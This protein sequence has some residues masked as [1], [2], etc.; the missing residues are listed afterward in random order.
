MDALQLFLI[1]HARA[2]SDAVA[3]ASGPLWLQDALLVGLTD[4]QLRL[5]PSEGD[6]SLAWLLW[7]ITRIEDVAMNVVLMAQ[8]QV[9]HQEQWQ[10][11][12][13]ITFG[14]VGTGMAEDDVAD[15]GARVDI[16]ALRAYRTA[17]GRRTRELVAAIEPE[18][19]ALPVTAVDVERAAA[20]GAFGAGA[21]WLRSFWEGRPKAWYLSWTAVGH[22]YLHLGEAMGI[23]GRLGLGRGR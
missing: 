13:R 1:E 19:L 23:K 10:Q 20:S 7:H 5:R 18:E 8:P 3:P 22:S 9:F 14:D 21:D 2:H 4:D 16:P 15:L 17:V 6:N 12:L 11:R